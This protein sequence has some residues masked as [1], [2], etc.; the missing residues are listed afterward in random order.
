MTHEILA[1]SPGLSI[2]RAE[3]PHHDL[4]LARRRSRVEVDVMIGAPDLTGLPGSGGCITKVSVPRV[5]AAP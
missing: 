4:V 2:A 5:K 3:D 1:D